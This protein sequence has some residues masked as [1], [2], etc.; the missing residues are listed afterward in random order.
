[1]EHAAYGGRDRLTRVLIAA[2]KAELTVARR[3]RTRERGAPPPLSGLSSKW[4]AQCDDGSAEFEL[5]AAVASLQ[6]AK[7]GPGELRQHLEPLERSGSRWIWSKAPGHEIV[8]T[9][10]DLV[11]DL[12]AILQRRIL[13]AGR[14][15]IEVPLDGCIRASPQALGALLRGEVNLDQLATLIEALALLD[16]GP[17]PGQLLQPRPQR[18]VALPPSY[19][20]IK[21]TLLGR[22]LK[23]SGEKLTIRPD[24]MVVGLLRAGDVW[25]A[26][27]RAARRLRAAGVTPRR[28]FRRHRDTPVTRDDELGRRFL[29]ALVVPV[30]EEPLLRAIGHCAAY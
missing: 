10:R 30:A 16:I 13:D 2:A 25:E 22:P 27:L 21:L 29:A 11:N 28:V 3:P 18:L 19:A 9:G 14:E 8:W 5:A 15:G 24:P 17:Q 20:M 23:V 7:Q 26:T 1:M 6:P 4:I 12:C